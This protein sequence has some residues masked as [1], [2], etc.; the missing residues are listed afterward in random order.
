MKTTS[1]EVLETTGPV[2]DQGGHVSL[3]R[4]RIEQLARTWI[5]SS[6]AVPNWDD[7]VHWSD[8]GPNTVNAV[9]LLDALNF[10]FWPNPGQPKWSLDYQ[11]KTF[12]GYMALAAGLKRA[13][14]AGDPLYSAERLA[15]LTLE[16][17]KEIFAGENEIPMLP[18][19]LANAQEV[20]QVL[21]EKYQG[22]FVNAI[23]SVSHS[24]IALTQLLVRDFPC[25]RD[26]TT[27]N[28]QL[29][30]FYK[31]AQITVI[32]LL[33]TFGG[34]GFGRFDDAHLLTAFADYK[35]PQVLEAQGILRYSDEL[36]E[37][38]NSYQL[39]PAGDP[40]EVEIRAGMVWAVEYLRQAFE[41]LGRPIQAYELDWFLWNVGQQPVPNERPYHRTRTI[42]Y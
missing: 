23:E 9:L 22:S 42:Y 35:I 27:Y 37:T 21:L 28:G 32:D 26:E 20:G 29:V 14:E 24:A 39:I 6:F 13:I 1:L 38:L 8:G 15:A 11:G 19:R 4:A 33:G 12:N 41:S 18:E 7:E 17:L 31:R 2:V 36:C 30:R 5:D 25:F 10:C 40:R 34:Q 3:D 16:D